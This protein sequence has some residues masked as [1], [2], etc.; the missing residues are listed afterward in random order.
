MYAERLI[1]NLRKW[2][3]IVVSLILSVVIFEELFYIRAMFNITSYLQEISYWH[4]LKSQF[5]QNLNVNLVALL[6]FFTLIV[7]SFR[8]PQIIEKLKWQILIADLFISMVFGYFAS[9]FFLRISIESLTSGIVIA[10]LLL[11]FVAVNCSLGTK[12]KIQIL[13]QLMLLSASLVAFFSYFLKSGAIGLPAFGYV[14]TSIMILFIY[15]LALI[16]F[17]IV[18]DNTPATNKESIGLFVVIVGLFTAVIA[19]VV[20]AL[21]LHCADTEGAYHFY[22]EVISKTIGGAPSISLI[23]KLGDFTRTH[24]LFRGSLLLLIVLIYNI[25]AFLKFIKKDN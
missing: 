17:P 4:I 19:V 8:T 21:D 20:F 16:L 15:V 7:V 6:F 14:K 2:E 1:A 18:T 13:P 24:I 11:V 23:D 3:F 9:I 12:L 25:L 5:Q 22:A 10:I